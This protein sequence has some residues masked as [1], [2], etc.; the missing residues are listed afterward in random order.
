MKEKVIFFA[1]HGPDR[2]PLSMPGCRTGTARDR[3]GGAGKKVNYQKG[4][5][6]VFILYTERVSYF[7][8]SVAK[9]QTTPFVTFVTRILLVSI[10]KVCLNND[11]LHRNNVALTRGPQVAGPKAMQASDIGVQW[12]G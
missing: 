9:F 3:N 5:F 4:G 1:V 7:F 10:H 12:P 11:Q 6:D 8:T 2:T